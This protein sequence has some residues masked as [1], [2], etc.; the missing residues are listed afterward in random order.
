ML[1]SYPILSYPLSAQR[2]QADLSSLCAHVILLILLCCGSY[3]VHFWSFSGTVLVCTGPFRFVLVNRDTPNDY[4]ILRYV[5]S[6][7]L[8]YST[9][10]PLSNLPTI[11]RWKKGKNRPKRTSKLDRKN[12]GPKRPWTKQP[13]ANGSSPEM[14]QDQNDLG[15]NWP[16]SSLSKYLAKHHNL[17]STLEQISNATGFY[18]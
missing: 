10:S 6:S 16:V 4:H 15:L 8:R 14:A 9:V 5:A 7:V 2:S 1:L 11:Y 12:Q 18:F 13:L 3:E 17:D